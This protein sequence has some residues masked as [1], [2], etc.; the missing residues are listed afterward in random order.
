MKNKAVTL[1]GLG[2][3]GLG[4]ANHLLSKAY[5]VYIWNRTASKTMALAERGAIVKAS[6]AEAIKSAPV[7]ISALPERMALQEVLFDVDWAHALSGR[8]IINVGSISPSRSQALTDACEAHQ[9]FYVE[10]AAMGSVNDI[11]ALNLQLLIGATESDY[12]RVND[13]LQD[14]STKVSLIGEVGQ[15]A[16]LKLALLQMSA[17]L[18]AAFSASIGLIMEQGVD[19]DVFMNHLRGSTFYAALFDQ[20]LPRLLARDYQNPNFPGRHLQRELALFL[21]QAEL[22]GLNVNSVESIHDLLSLTGLKGLQ[23][24]DF[25]ALHDVVYPPREG[26]LSPFFE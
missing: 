12:L 11:G 26:K 16:A 3:M 14:I 13:L 6:A 9:A 7:I 1:F 5:T 19:I 10:V 20:K 18:T 25:S 2:A 17:S 23:D 15:A 22:S 8:T 24:L 4:L 21:E